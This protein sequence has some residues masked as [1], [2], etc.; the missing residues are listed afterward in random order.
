MSERLTLLAC[1][2]A[3]L[4]GM[5]GLF[6]RREGRAGERIASAL[7]V[8]AGI[9]GLWAAWLAVA[10]PSSRG[11]SLPWA[12]PGGALEIRADGLSAMFLA[13]IFFVS[14]LG[15]IYGLSYWPQAEH[16]RDGRKLRLFYGLLT[17]AMGLLVVARNGV[18]F[19]A[20]W[21]VMAIAAFLSLAAEDDKPVV[22]EV[23]YVY[24]VATRIG[25]LCLFAMFA[26]L[27]GAT[28]RLHFDARGLDP[29][30]PAG[31]AVFLLALAGFGLKAGIMPLHVWLPGAH[32]NAPTHVSS[33]MSGVLI[34]MGIYGI[35]RTAA[36][37]AAPPFW[38][39]GTLLALGAASAILGVAF[40]I[41]QHDV[42]RLLAYHSVENIGIICMGL[43]LALI[44]RAVGRPELVI[45]GLAGALLHVWNH[46]LFKALLFLAAGAV[47]HSTG[48]RELDRLGSLLRRMPG[49]A[50]LFLVGAVA[51]CGL[52]PLNGFVSE[53]FLYMGFFRAA[54]EPTG[55]WW[56]PTAFAAPALALVGALAVACFV[57]VF[58]AVFLGEPRSDD[59]LRAH[60]PG[61]AMLGPMIALAACCA[62]IGIAP[63]LVAPVLDSAAASFGVHAP[64][65]S[66][67]PLSRIALAAVL[68]LG[69]LLLAGAALAF[70]VRRASAAPTWDCGYAVPTARMQYTSSSFAQML[71][72]MFAFA[73]RPEERAPR[74]D[75]PFPPSA[76]YH[77][78]VPDVVLDRAVAPALRAAGRAFEWLRFI[79][80]GDVQAYLTYILLT[81]VLFLVWT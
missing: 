79:Q 60:E 30:S 41:G 50:L 8:A 18:L 27:M 61:P 74:V 10:A 17:A 36:S 59:A 47:I 71:V 45:L 15:A 69:T 70:R 44:G 54:V 53:L 72:G 42:K 77:G 21:E 25:T 38:W 52:P 6:M 65:A 19:L 80:R 1:A 13:Q 16:P 78:S 12:V 23:G 73:L 14:A 39:G 34:K 32:A 81:L 31:S 55:R 3:A 62:A 40:A 51:I 28:G 29:R 37:V 43:G 49:T 20:A 68:L 57:K 9:A 58:G 46:G 7:V 5:P 2:L 22:R 75:G 76:A 26:L 48:T 67:V 66:Q 64:L 24:L 4:S 33:L 11:I 63:A 56:I 35:A